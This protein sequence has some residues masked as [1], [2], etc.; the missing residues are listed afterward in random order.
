MSPVTSQWI[1]YGATFAMQ[2]CS[3]IMRGQGYSKAHP[4]PL[5]GRHGAAAY[6]HLLAAWARGVPTR[7]IKRLRDA[8]PCLLSPTSALERITDSSQT[9]RQVRNVP[10]AGFNAPIRSHRRSSIRRLDKLSNI[11]KIA[12]NS[13]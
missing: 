12:V 2:S 5:E 13:N 7:K 3:R 8:D 11:A 1:P 10:G 9:S 6:G 4:A